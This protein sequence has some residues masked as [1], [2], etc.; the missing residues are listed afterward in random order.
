MRLLPSQLK[1][2]IIRIRKNSKGIKRLVIKTTNGD[3]VEVDDFSYLYE[4]LK[5]N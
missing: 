4:I 1:G 5:H 3:I 2:K